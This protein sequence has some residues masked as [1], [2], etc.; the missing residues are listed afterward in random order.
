MRFESTVGHIEDANSAS[1]GKEAGKAVSGE[2]DAHLT[3]SARNLEDDWPSFVRIGREEN[4]LQPILGLG[5]SC[6]DLFMR[7]I[8]AN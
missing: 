7:R 5:S 4:T 8:Q 6:V 2:V 1:G 3:G